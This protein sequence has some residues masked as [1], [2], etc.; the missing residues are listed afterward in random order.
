MRTVCTALFGTLDA[1]KPQTY[2]P[3]VATADK[4]A[5]RGTHKYAVDAAIGTA[6][7]SALWRPLETADCAPFWSTKQASECATV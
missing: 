7:Q 1:T 2:A 5:K 6:Y 4:A 3:A